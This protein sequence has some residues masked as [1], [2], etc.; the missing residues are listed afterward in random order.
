MNAS[1]RR[2]R[3][4]VARRLLGPALAAGGLLA[5]IAGAYALVV[6]ALG[7]SPGAGERT[8][9]ALSIAATA[10]VALVYPRVRG[11]AARATRWLL[12]AQRPALDEPLRL[13]TSRLSRAIPLEELLLQ[14][15]ETLR[16]ALGLRAAEIWTGTG[17]ELERTVSDPDRG[18]GHISLAAEQPVVAREGVAG[19]GFVSVWLKPLLAGREGALLRV[20]PA[21]RSGEL[22]GL[23]VAERPSDDEPFGDREDQVLGELAR[24]VALA[25]HNARLDS[26]LQASLEAL[27]RQADELRASRARIVV[28]ADNERRRIERDLHDGAQQRL[29]G[30]MVKLEEAR[31]LAGTDAG[32]TEAALDV[33]KADLHSALD[34]LRDLAQGIYPPL[35]SDSGLVDAISAAAARAPMPCRVEDDGVGRYPSEL[36]AAVY[37]CCLEALQ[38]TSKH[39]GEGARASISIRGEADRLAFVVEDDGAGFDPE[40]VARGVGLTNM[41]DRLG[42]IGGRLEVESAPRQGARIRGSVPFAGPTPPGAPTAGISESLRTDI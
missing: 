37:F 21:V 11:R 40:Q 27:R 22:L 15:A 9:L 41:R 31:E 16:R 28:S 10:V 2:R 26:A 33:L 25:L 20:A 5:V 7:H 14:T 35:L 23:I 32:R 13:F 12:R 19:E 8:V 42:A 30:L 34:E 6:L 17:G 29:V 1:R 38:N 4:T 18:P 3:S 39:A 36:E 24:Q